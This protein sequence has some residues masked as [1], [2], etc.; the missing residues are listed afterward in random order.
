MSEDRES[1]P[2]GFESPYE[3]FVWKELG[4][5]RELERQGEY[6]SALAYAVSL[7]KYL[8]PEVRKK[9]EE[10]GKLIAER[11]RAALNEART[12]IW[13]NTQV[14]QNRVAERLGREYLDQFMTDL[15][16]S[17]GRRAYMERVG[18]KPKAKGPGRLRINDE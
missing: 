8:H 12:G 5:I 16:N 4:I 10:Q 1:I 2:R 7:L 18:A 3:S 15:G 6:Y 14:L 13:Y 17:L 9:H 11:I